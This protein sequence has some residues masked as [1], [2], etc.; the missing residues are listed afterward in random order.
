MI[1]KK[2]SWHYKLVK[3]KKSFQ[4]LT[5]DNYKAFDYIS[6]VYFA[7]CV[8]IF[9]SIT[10]LYI[11]FYLIVNQGINIQE[12]NPVYDLILLGCIL[13]TSSFFGFMIL[14]SIIEQI[15]KIFNNKWRKLVIV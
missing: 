6:E 8:D 4:N 2:E 13:A 15:V 11:I 9:L 12:S 5:S 10:V 3:H 7:I 1:V 14:M